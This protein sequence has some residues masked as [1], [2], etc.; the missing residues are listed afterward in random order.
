VNGTIKYGT[1]VMSSRLSDET[2]ILDIQ[3]DG[4]GIVGLAYV[5]IYL[6]NG[7][8]SGIESDF[9]G[10]KCLH[11][12]VEWTDIFNTFDFSHHICCENQAGI[13]LIEKSNRC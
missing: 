10:I 6:F 2:R 9:Q 13:F 5:L 7:K 4:G 8:E 1:I 11:S 12:R 3:V